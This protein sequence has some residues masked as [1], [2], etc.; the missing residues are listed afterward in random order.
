MRKEG[1]RRGSEWGRERR[2]RKIVK[3]RE[4]CRECLPQFAPLLMVQLY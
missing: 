2:G 1:G 3:G 4:E